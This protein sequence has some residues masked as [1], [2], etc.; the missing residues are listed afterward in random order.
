MRLWLCRAD[1]SRMMPGRADHMMRDANGPPIVGRQKMHMRVAGILS[2][3]PT[4]RA[5]TAQPGINHRESGRLADGFP[6]SGVLGLRSSGL[7]STLVK[8][9]WLPLTHVMSPLRCERALQKILDHNAPLGSVCFS[10]K[11][12]QA[13]HVRVA[14]RL[15]LHGR[16]QITQHL[17]HLGFVHPGA[18]VDDPSILSL[19]L[20]TA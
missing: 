8:A 10:Q 14:R 12:A 16:Q 13:S 9:A 15:A 17:V 5:A 11:L 20:K 2:A 18:H 7:P 6:L 1:R 4:R 3:G 19:H